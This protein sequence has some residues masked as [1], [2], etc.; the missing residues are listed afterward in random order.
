MTDDQMA[1]VSIKLNPDDYQ[2]RVDQVLKDHARKAKMPGFRPGKVPMGLIKKQY[3]TSVL[4]DEVNRMIGTEL[5]KYIDTEKLDILGNPLPAKEKSSDVNWEAPANMEFF[6]D[7]AIAPEVKLDV[8]KKRKFD[9]YKVEATEKDVENSLENIAKRNGEMTDM[10]EVGET[11]LVKVQWVELNDAGEIL[12]GGILHSSS[13]AI[14]TIKD[15]DTLKLF[16]GKKLDEE[17]E[18]AP[19]KVSQNDA[20]RAAMLGVQ[21]GE[22]ESV[23][24]RFKVKIEKV[25]RLKP[26]E[27]NEALFKKLY[28]DGSITDVEGLKER[29]REDYR[30]Y[31]VGESDRKLKNDIVLALLKEADLPLPEDF[32]KRWLLNVNQEKQVT[33]EQI[34]AEYPQY[35]ESLK[36]QLI[37]NKVI[38]EADIK[39]SE[40]EL[41]EGVANHVRMQFAQYGINQADDEMMQQMVDSFMKRED[42][43]R[44]VNEVLYDRKILEF[45]KEKCQLKEKTVDSEKFYEMLTKE[46][47]G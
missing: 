35:S 36:W 31:F 45:F 10:K 15:E 40:E 47:Q 30:N 32:L 12:E 41:K 19:T 38:R 25:Q 2:P 18:V 37:E 7:M 17:F 42:E 20:D 14:D 11:D 39:V 26:A 16:K 13:V 3:G 24:D 21:K 27:L 34:E 43:V 22:V 44:K 46:R 1:L 5:Y 8:A 33:S 4:V 6:F 29:V 23:S 28:P 9:Y